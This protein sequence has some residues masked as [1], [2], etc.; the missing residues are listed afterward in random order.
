VLDDIG[1]KSVTFIRVGASVH[2]PLLPSGG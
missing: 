2:G 1:R